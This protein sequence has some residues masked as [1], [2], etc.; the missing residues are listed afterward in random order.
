MSKSLGNTVGLLEEPEEIW[1]KLRPAV[2][3]PKRQRRTDPGTP[4]VCNIYALHKAF[5]PPATVEH[6]AIQCSTAGWGCIEC[7]KVLHESMEREL[8]PIRSRAREIAGN[9]SSVV[10]AL[11]AGAER[12]RGV[13]RETM[14]EVREKMGLA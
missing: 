12:A 5:S 11:E 3:D 9:P 6:V 14:R 4:E 8:V 1:A 13:A 2:T 7:K 10:D